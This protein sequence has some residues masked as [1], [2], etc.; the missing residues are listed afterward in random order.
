MGVVSPSIASTER[1]HA[2][3]TCVLRRRLTPPERDHVQQSSSVFA[4]VL[5]HISSF[6]PVRVAPFCKIL[7]PMLDTD[8]KEVLL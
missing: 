5:R 2:A 4:C 7:L 3:S 8:W 6:G 1:L